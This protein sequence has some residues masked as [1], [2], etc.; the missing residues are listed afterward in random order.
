MLWTNSAT[1]WR[2]LSTII[3]IQPELKKQRKMAFSIRKTRVCQP[4]P[5][6]SIPRANII[7][8]C[9]FH[10]DEGCSE[11]CTTYC[12]PPVETTSE[13]QHWDDVSIIREVETISQCCFFDDVHFKSCLFQ[14]GVV[15]SIKHL[16][17]CC[18]AVLFVSPSCYLFQNQ[19]GCWNIL[20][21]VS[22]GRFIFCRFGLLNFQVSTQKIQ[23]VPDF[24][25]WM[26]G[27]WSW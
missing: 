8:S 7:C 10:V 2:Q 13:K 9:I 21:F 25:A 17:V 1:Q 12:K 6:W 20:L 11:C 5:S 14:H 24:I 19:V 4:S 23:T 15:C 26:S 18:N 3:M 16:I 27:S 22:T